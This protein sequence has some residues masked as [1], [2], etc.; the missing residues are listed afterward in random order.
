MT[1]E[2]KMVAM[3]SRVLDVA[4][5]EFILNTARYNYF[6]KNGIGRFIHHT[7]AEGSPQNIQKSLTDWFGL[8][9]DSKAISASH[10]EDFGTTRMEGSHPLLDYCPRWLK[11]RCNKSDQS[12]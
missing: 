2:N 4:W 7:P 1:N 11:Q 9:P 3:P 5:H 12:K 6:C 10:P 8:A